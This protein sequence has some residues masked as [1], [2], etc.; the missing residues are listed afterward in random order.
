MLIVKNDLIII[1]SIYILNV[2]NRF[3]N[4]SFKKGEGFI[5]QQMVVLPQYM[6]EKIENNPLVG[7]LYITDIGYFPHAD[8]HFRKRPKGSNEYIFIY[9]IEGV[10]WVEIDETTYELMPNSYLMIPKYAAHR[11]WTDAK[12]PWTIYWMH[13]TGRKATFFFESYLN[14]KSLEVRSAPF[15]ENRI[16]VF[17]RSILLLKQ[18]FT[19]RMFEIVNIRLMQFISSFIYYDEESMLLEFSEDPVTRSI[20]YMRENIN[21]NLKV[22]DIAK[23]VEMSVSYF[24]DNF[25]K[26]TGFSPI[27]YFN[28]LRIQRACQYLQFTNL[29][30]KDICYKLGFMDPY[31]FSRIFKKTIGLSPKNY[32]IKNA[33]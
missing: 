28:D 14:G 2:M 18:G 21:Q 23:K 17:N 31:Y 7:D 3:Y 1:H 8:N 33:S 9:N 30:I 27:H 26:K 10:G 16:A 19:Q 29:S 6:K 5:G 13:F 24:S 20:S 22:E 15:E 25:K 32:R 11:Y 12:A 4:K